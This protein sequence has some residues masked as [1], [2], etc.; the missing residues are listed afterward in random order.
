MPICIGIM[1]NKTA[2][3]DDKNDGAIPIALFSFS[4]WS[5][6]IKNTA[7]KKDNKIKTI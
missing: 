3:N 2:T 1:S 4:K 7:Y 5:F 6:I